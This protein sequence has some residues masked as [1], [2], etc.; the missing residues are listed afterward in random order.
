MTV[1]T[2]PYDKLLPGDLRGR[3]ILIAGTDASVAELCQVRG[4]IVFT[5]SDASPARNDFVVAGDI[6]SDRNPLARLDKMIAA[7]GDTLFV[8]LSV[9]R[10]SGASPMRFMWS[11]MG[12][13]PAIALWPP[14]RRGPAQQTFHFT[15]SFLLQYLKVLRQD[16]ATVTLH[17]LKSR[18][19]VIAK[20]RR[21]GE[22]HILAGV[23]AIGKSTLLQKLRT[24]EGKDLAMRLHLDL[25]EPWTFATY[26]S[27]LKDTAQSLDRVLVQYNYSSPLTHGSLHRFEYGILDL[28]QSAARV[29]VTTMWLPAEKLK[30]RYQA[31]RVPE[32]MSSGAE[33]KRRRIATKEADVSGGRKMKGLLSRLG[34]HVRSAH[35]RRKTDR[36]VGLYSSQDAL[37]QQFQAWLKF[38]EANGANTSVLL[39]DPVYEVISVTEW[40]RRHSAA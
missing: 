33:F 14:G 21:I 2:T 1:S 10:L 25:S 13:F 5:L 39:Q 11:G 24:P 27:L 29:R 8:D 31:G 28:M 37:N 23:P 34:I 12:A 26:T 22:L 19:I 9:E 30:A 32:N 40:K 4:G 17:R 35:I 20:R 7:T 36:F 16:F 15:E 6:C 3:S 38:A 18:I